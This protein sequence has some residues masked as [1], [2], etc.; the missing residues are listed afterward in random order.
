M[1]PRLILSCILGYFGFL[2]LIAWFTSR[3]ANNASYFIGNKASPWIAVAFG[4]L[5]DSLSGVTFISVPGDVGPRNFSY[6]QIVFGYIV[7]YVVIAQIL[8]PLYYR[9]NLISIYSYLK[10]RFGT[11]SQKTGSFFFLLSRT[12]G[13]AVRLYL[14]ATVLQVFVFDQWPIWGNRILPYWLTVTFIIGLILI[15]TLKGGI[16]TLV[17]T[18][19]FQS[20]F[21]LLGVVLSITAIARQ[22]DLG[23]G[24]LVRTVR[25][26]EHSQIFFWDWRDR[27]YF[28]KQFISGA[29]IAIVMTGLD[30]NM[31]QKNLSCRS[32]KAA[33]KN[34][35][36]FTLVMVLVNVLFV[37]LGALLYEYAK[38]KGINLPAQT[39]R[40]FPL[41]A[42]QHLGAFAALV[43]I[44]GL[45]AATFSSADSVLTTLTTSFCIDFLGMDQQQGTESDRVRTR[46]MIHFGFAILLLAVILAFKALNKQSVIQA[47]F[48]L[49]S[50]TYGPLLG[51][52]AFG[53]FHRTLVM[54]RWVPVVCL[55]SPLLCW[56]VQKK[57]V[58]LFGGYQFGFELLLVNG[59][60][61]YA[62]LW[63]IRR[64]PPLGDECRPSLK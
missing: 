7:G 15:Y 18:D 46:K 38:F 42:L 61:T 62:G 25:E 53:L 19:T 49:A 12:T 57:S 36:A 16:K 35:Y 28:W 56:A 39:D 23:L 2:L 60:F 29:F 55:V 59:L 31:M 33:Q 48:T 26:S 5:G 51:L 45:T 3:K 13:A 4:L 32:L 54:D 34:I 27:N 40:V 14:A 9:L 58:L 10:G 22:L 44:V 50:Y 63:L 17:W 24:D 11:A 47:V 64:R 37:S 20:T 6:L 30:Q 1:A 43:F 8:L 52:F 21:L 41:L